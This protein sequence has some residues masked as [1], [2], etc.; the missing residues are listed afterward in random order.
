MKKSL[1]ETN[2]SYQFQPRTKS[3]KINYVF[4]LSL[5]YTKGMVWHFE[6]AAALR[7]LREKGVMVIG[8]G[9]LVHNLGIVDWHNINGPIMDWAQS[10]DEQ[11][12]GLL[13]EGN[14]EAL[15]HP[16]RL[17]RQASLAIPTPEHYL[18]MLYSLGLAHKDEPLR[19]LYEGIQYGSISMRCF[20]IGG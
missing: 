11:A 2:Y 10:F 18:P 9:N 14:F 17:G 16:E 12:K 4:Q 15:V 1:H 3:F 7:K 13:T 20:A 19:M 8:S 5:D 6:L